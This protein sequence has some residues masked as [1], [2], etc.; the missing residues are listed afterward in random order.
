M[1]PTEANYTEWFAC[2]TRYFLLKEGYAFFTFG[3][4][5]VAEEGFPSAS[6]FAEGTRLTGLAFVAPV[7]PARGQ[8]VSAY[9][10]DPRHHERMTASHWML[11]ALPQSADVLDQQLLHQKV[12]FAAPGDVEVSG[13][14]V[15]L[16]R[17]ALPFKTVFARMV[18]GSLG[19]DASAFGT[20]EEFVRAVGGQQA[21]LYLVVNPR[22]RVVFALYGGG[23]WA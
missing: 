22:D 4:G 13:E 9:G 1:V 20:A 7:E 19:S 21:S 12:L 18:D 3:L 14:G 5:Q 17:A 6:L 23:G 10:T 11:Y 15:L 16:A 2:S 8:R